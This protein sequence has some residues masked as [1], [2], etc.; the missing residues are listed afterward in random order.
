[1]SALAHY[2]EK[3][4]IP[5]TGISLVREHTVGFRPPRFLWVP[6]ELGRPFGAPNAPEFQTKVL[7]SALGLLESDE[8]PVLLEDFPDDAPAPGI[9]DDEQDSGGWVCPVN[10]LP[11]PEDRTELAEAVITE[12]GRLAPWYELALSTRGRSTVGVSGLDIET[13][14]KL[15]VGFVEGSTENPHSEWSLAETLKFASE[16][17]RAWYMEAA[18]ARPGRA[19]SIDVINWFW[20]ETVAGK[21]FID[22]YTTGSAMDDAHM[23]VFVEGFSVPRSQ[24]HLLSK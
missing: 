5:T 20:G 10:L 9:E 21:I 18:T 24:K 13:A 2:I 14:A 11:P 12:I 6:F 1:M 8:G 7:R 22:V 3:E 17:I 19:T 15:L 4:G 23:K 16:D